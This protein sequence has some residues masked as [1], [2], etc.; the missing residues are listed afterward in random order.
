[1]G[2]NDNKVTFYDNDGT[3]MDEF[4]YNE[5][6]KQ[7][8]FTCAAFNPSGES[9]VVGSFNRIHVFNY[10]ATRNKWQEAGVRGLS[11]RENRGRREWVAGGGTE[12][13][14][15]RQEREAPHC[16]DEGGSAREDRKVSQGEGTSRWHDIAPCDGSA[17]QPSAHRGAPRV[18]PGLPWAVARVAAR[19][20]RGRRGGTTRATILQRGRT[21]V[22]ERRH[23]RGGNGR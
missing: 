10:N 6:E 8:E 22:L 12:R 7:K 5:D 4:S 14:R 23:D 18:E 19:A 2:G 21:V 9:V 17:K 16:G 1:M 20:G 11:R 13:G 15:Q 3:Y